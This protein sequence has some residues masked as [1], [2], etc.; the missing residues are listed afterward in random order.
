MTVASNAAEVWDLPGALA[1]VYPH[2]DQILQRP[3]VLVADSGPTDLSELATRAADPAF[4]L[5]RELAV[6]GRDLIL[7]GFEGATT[8][9]SKATM[10]VRH[11]LMRAVAERIGSTPLVVGGIGRGALLARYA[12]AWS[13]AQRMDHQTSLYFSYNG[14]APATKAETEALSELGDMP[15]VPRLLKITAGV[16]DLE[17]LGDGDDAYDHSMFD[18]FIHTPA[19]AP[20]ALLNDE[21]GTW[22]LDRLP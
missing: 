14:T 22:L 11:A 15:R 8:E 9:L 1:W 4:P 12:L 21:A 7:V 5:Q 16:A 13:E 2:Q 10:P 17:G 20:S 3:F 18:D 19:A 6:R